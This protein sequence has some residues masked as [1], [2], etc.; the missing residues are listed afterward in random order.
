MVKTSQAAAMASAATEPKAETD[1]DSQLQQLVKELQEEAIAAAA[2]AR[3]LVEEREVLRSSLADLESQLAEANGEVAALQ[4]RLQLSEDGGE[5]ATI[6]AQQL[7]AEV[8][9]LRKRLDVELQAARRE[10]A[11]L[12]AQLKDAK[13]ETHGLGL[14]VRTCNTRLRCF[15]VVTSCGR[16]EGK[17]DCGTAVSMMSTEQLSLPLLFCGCRFNSDL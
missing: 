11:E 9:A 14:A 2:H 1:P 13:A 17:N 6:R 3:K 15:V 5:E 7:E 4:Q 10:N 12:G 16:T 8:E